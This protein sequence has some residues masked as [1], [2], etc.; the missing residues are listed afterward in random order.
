MKKKIGFILCIVTVIVPTLIYTQT[1]SDFCSISPF[2]TRTVP[3]NIVIVLDNSAAMLAAAYPLPDH[4]D[5]S[6][7][8]SYVGYFDS[9]STYCSTTDMF[10][11]TSG[12]CESGDHGPYPGALLNWAAMSRFDILMY[13]LAGGLGAAEPASVDLAGES[14]NRGWTKTT[15]HYPQCDFTVS[16]DSLFITGAG[17]A[18]QNPGTKIIVRNGRKERGLIPELV[19]RNNDGVRDRFAPRIAVMSFQSLQNDITMTS[20]IS[21]TDSLDALYRAIAGAAP[22]E[23]NV[24][25]P[26]GKAVLRTIEFYKNGCPVCSA[27]ADPVDSMQCRKN[28]VISLSSGDATDIPALYSAQHLNEEIRKAHT[29][30]IRADRDGTQV[31]QY[32]S[33]NIFGS[34]AGKDIMKGF[35]K[36]GGFADANGNRLPDL[37]HE[38]DRNGDS[39]PDTYFEAADFPSIRL[40]L[41]RAFS[42]ISAQAASGTAA[43][44]LSG[45]A[46]AA[47][48]IMQAF[49]LPAR[50]EGAGEV[51]WTGYMQSLWTDPDGNLREDSVHDYKLMLNQDKIVKF[52]AP[53]RGN[54]TKAALFTTQSDGGGGTFARCSNPEIRESAHVKSIWEAGRSLALRVPSDRIIFTSK[55]IIR[56]AKVTHTFSETPYPLFQ[57]AMNSTL[58]SALNPDTD[59]TADA[60]VRYIRGECLE[61]G[62]TGDT[63][64]GSGINPAFRDRRI[65]IDGVSRVWKLGDIMNSTPKVSGGMPLNAYHVDYA[66]RS[67]Y[68]YIADNRYQRKSS[69]VFAGAND[70]MLHA[71]RG[72]Y[73]KDGGL[74]GS[75]K[76]LLRNFFGSGD[77]EHEQLGEE[78]WAYIPFNAFPYI[79]YLADPDYCHINYTDLSVKVFDVSFSGGPGATKD[80][81]SWRTILLGG[82]RFGGACGTGGRPAD[83]PA[84]APADVGF[85][86]YFA[87]DVTLPERPVPLWEFSDDDMG[88]AASAPAIVRTGDKMQN[89]KW[90]VI[91]GSGSK[92]LPKAGDDIGRSAPGCLYILNLGTGDLVKKITLDHPAIVADL[93]AIDADKD[94]IT[95]KIYFGTSFQSNTAWMGKMMSLNV[96]AVLEASG[97]DVAW[98]SSFGNV[99]FSGKYPFTASPEA[100]KDTKGAIWVYAGSGKYFSDV[101]ETDESQQIVFG[102]QDKNDLINE[103]SL[104]DATNVLTNGVVTGT[105][106]VCGYDA[107]MKSF[108]FRDI[109]TAVKP[110]STTLTSTDPGW[111]ISLSGRERVI[112][113]PVAVGGILDFLSY[114]PDSDPCTYGGDSYLYSV[115]YTTGLAPA[116]VAIRSPEISTGTG[117]SVTVHKSIS[118]GSGAPPAGDAIMIQPPK[119]GS[120]QLQKNIQLAT[121]RMA[122]AENQPLLS[123]VS[124]IVHWLKK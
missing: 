94:Y 2:I 25:A 63:P 7:P 40:S 117:G 21:E 87:L 83:P 45:S 14:L 47:G 37:S 112:S 78:I 67:Y 39:L 46:G 105:D 10:Y 30:D 104:F 27:C 22:D 72:G 119:D 29:S 26:L 86:S 50:Q 34:A 66:D 120:E 52:F 74:A 35:S 111:R 11:E 18:L 57:T 6:S 82:M 70:G 8:T 20:C 1:M 24:E 95:E 53:D 69:V 54:E 85:S 59:Y 108:R 77:G 13:V 114:R 100:A 73:L 76:A 42:D 90:Y 56:G 91:L 43:S 51:L 41:G 33:V 61:S 71:F 68:D 113:R 122:E 9:R 55:K 80:Q 102:L 123:I 97:A 99:L 75:V 31:I 81:N 101:D 84:G 12:N 62:V 44:A 15:P 28:F 49:F 115:S 118:L 121:G 110:A 19:D 64:C 48:G 116:R 103:A 88:F 17:C 4:Y 32:Y 65:A 124:K 23:M 16:N 107:E 106:R 3:P 5:N 92:V 79:K 58:L 36:Y 60:I 89:G 96:P 109:V 98:S 93:L 38:W